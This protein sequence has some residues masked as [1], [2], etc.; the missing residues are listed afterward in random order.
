MIT[1]IVWTLMSGQKRKGC[2]DRFSSDLRHMGATCTGTS[3]PPA[4][5]LRG[6][7]GLAR[8]SQK[9]K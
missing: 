4:Y 2:S 3:S 7:A 8:N 5:K 6:D 1:F 9:I